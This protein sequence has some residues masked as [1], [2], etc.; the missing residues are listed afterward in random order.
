M[1]LHTSNIRNVIFEENTIHFAR[2]AFDSD[3]LG[4]YQVG[5][6]LAA[7]FKGGFDALLGIGEIPLGRAHIARHSVGLVEP[8]TLPGMVG[9]TLWEQQRV[10][11]LPSRLDQLSG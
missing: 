5:F 11:I 10:C 7:P 2:F 8:P 9:I 6:E 3:V 1:M 4:D